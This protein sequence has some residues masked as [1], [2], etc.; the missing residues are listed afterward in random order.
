MTAVPEAAFFGWNEMRE[1]TELLFVDEVFEFVEALLLAD[2]LDRDFIGFPDEE[3]APPVVFEEDEQEE[4]DVV[5]DGDKAPVDE[6]GDEEEADRPDE[7][8]DAGDTEEEDEGEWE[9]EVYTG[10]R[11][12]LLFDDDDPRVNWWCILWI[13]DPLQLEEEEEVDE[14]DPV[15]DRIE[16]LLLLLLDFLLGFLTPLLL[17]PLEG[18]SLLIE[19]PNSLLMLRAWLL[20]WMLSPGKTLLISVSDPEWEPGGVRGKRLADEGGEEDK[21]PGKLLEE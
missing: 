19:T 21:N 7:D 2:A 15:G 13:E 18:N 10:R 11:E 8:E 14:V 9:E 6:E 17:P 20:Q 12:E 1:E 3:V 5:E 4:L 16:L